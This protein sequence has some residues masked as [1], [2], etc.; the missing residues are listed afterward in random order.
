M[1]PQIC[2]GWPWRQ[3]PK[4]TRLELERLYGKLLKEFQN[5]A[6]HLQRKWNT[7]G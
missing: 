6:H 4:Y 2:S 7:H 1:G 5:G 3:V